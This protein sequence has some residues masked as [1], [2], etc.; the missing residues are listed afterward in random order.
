MFKN[1]LKVAVRNVLR[2]KG[3]SAINML[4][5]AIG[6]ACSIIV[7]LW[8]QDEMSYD[9]FH[10]YADR[11]FSAVI[12]Y[13]SGNQEGQV[14]KTNPPLAPTMMAEIPEI[15]S[16]TR[17]LHAVNKLVTYKD[18]DLNFL[19]NGIYYADSTIFN[20][21]TIPLITGDPTDLLTRPKTI[22]ITQEIAQKYF[23]DKD[24][25]GK[26]LVFDNKYDREVVGVV[27]AWPANSHWH[28]DM[29][30]S[31]IT[32][33]A[34]TDDSWLSNYVNTYFKIRKGT[35]IDVVLP[36][37][38]KLV[39][40]HKDPLLEAALGM[41][42]EEWQAQG[43][44]SDHLA[45][46]IE[47]IYLHGSTMDPIGKSGDIRYVYLFAVIGLLVLFVACINFMSLTTARSGIRAKEIGMRKVF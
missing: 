7:F 38:N 17:F 29:L 27:K 39:H 13:K 10:H 34:A 2:H 20:V 16:A 44:R 28:F 47:D 15:E 37:I 21:F 32:I 33:G 6:I 22:V 41:S 43:N 25:I 12:D 8:I 14:N 36:K 30:A 35:S 31:M 9:S 19:E 23:G 4:G 26:T 5:L 24:P 11:I 45:V 42:M 40:R 46:P 3:I 18:G 1:Y